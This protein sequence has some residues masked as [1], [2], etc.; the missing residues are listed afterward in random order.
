MLSGV[1][2]KSA[3]TLERRPGKA[4]YV[5]VKSVVLLA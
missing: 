5:Q 3:T 2:R 1:T 4:I